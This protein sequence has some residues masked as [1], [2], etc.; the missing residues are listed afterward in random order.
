M[1][2]LIPSRVIRLIS[3]IIILPCLSCQINPMKD[4]TVESYTPD[5]TIVENLSECEISVTFNS[6]VDKISLEKELRFTKNN[7]TRGGTVLW[8][9]NRKF[10]FTPFEPLFSPGNYSLSLST[11]VEDI[12]G[13]SLLNSFFYSFSNEDDEQSPQVIS[14]SPEDGAGIDDNH[15]S[16][17]IVFSEPM[18]L[19]SLLDAFSLT[20]STEGSFSWNSEQ[21]VLQYHPYFDLAYPVIYELTINNSAKDL[22]GN[23]LDDDYSFSFQLNCPDQSPSILERHN[24]N[25]YILTVESNETPYLD[26]NEGWEKGWPIIFVWDRAIDIEG[27]MSH[28]TL[29]PDVNFE[30]THP[31]PEYQDEVTLTFPDG[32]IWGETYQCRISGGVRDIYLKESEETLFYM[33]VDGV[34]SKPPAVM[35]VAILADISDTQASLINHMDSLDFAS[36][37]SGGEGFIDIYIQLVSIDN[38]STENLI[39]SFINNF[40]FSAPST[41]LTVTPREVVRIYSEDPSL[42][43]PPGEMEAVLRMYFDWED[44]NSGGIGKITLADGFNDGLDHSLSENFQF[45]IQIE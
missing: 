21:N 23:N 2:I 9:N 25:G 12:Y 19:S 24:G 27:F 1:Y 11:D 40:D 31:Y 6:D 33:K 16:I 37:I 30:V 4:L 15:P 7:Q 22:I 26:I 35:D 28:L 5:Q 36:Y 42:S 45:W 43:R 10:I 41:A 38:T 8:E 32:L 14:T 44:Q 39:M 3:M 29:S 13:N 17:E 20:P 18:D 34:L